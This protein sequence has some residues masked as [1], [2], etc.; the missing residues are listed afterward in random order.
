MV[1]SAVAELRARGLDVRLDVVG[2][3]AEDHPPTDDVTFYGPVDKR[4]QEQAA[5]LRRLYD[6][7]HLF[8]MPTRFE[9]YG[10]VFAEAAAYGLPVVS[11]ATGGV[12]SV[13]RDGVTGVLIPLDATARDLANAIGA[14]AVDPER[15]RRM[16]AAALADSAER[17]DWRVWGDRCGQEVLRALNASRAG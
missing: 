10:I 6:E 13:I 9:C 3:P 16:S 5:L 15:Y 11:R 1:A 8:V 2:P 4:V 17:L 7:A 12:P 14:L